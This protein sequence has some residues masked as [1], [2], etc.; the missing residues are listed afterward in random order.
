MKTVARVAVD[1][2]AR[3][4]SS[5]HVGFADDGRGAR[6]R[7]PGLVVRL[8]TASEFSSSGSSCSLQDDW[9]IILLNEQHGSSSS[10]SL[11]EFVPCA[12]FTMYPVGEAQTA[13]RP[14][15]SCAGKR[16]EEVMHIFAKASV[17]ADS[18]AEIS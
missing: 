7:C 18:R 6:H 11:R 8:L 5:V 13:T 17:Q 10:G 4:D 9:K 15:G 3:R 1:P 16:A 14:V 12:K 2:R